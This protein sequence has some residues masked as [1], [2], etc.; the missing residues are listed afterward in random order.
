MDENK[1]KELKIMNRQDLLQEYEYY[2]WKVI[3]DVRAYE[4]WNSGNADRA[5]SLLKKIAKEYKYYTLWFMKEIKFGTP[6]G[7]IINNPDFEKIERLIMNREIEFWESGSGQS[8]IEYSDGNLTSTL[9]I[10]IA[11]DYGFY[12]EFCKN[13]K[14]YIILKDEDFK[15]TTEVYIEGEPILVPR[16]MFIDKKGSP[17]WIYR[18]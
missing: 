8:I 13:N 14:Y 6:M 12:V 5:L 9:Y 4:D 1:K 18:W 16:S 3:Y 2:I 7:E 11:E 10:C 15:D 17:G